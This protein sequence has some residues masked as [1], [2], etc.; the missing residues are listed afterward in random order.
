MVAIAFWNQALHMFWLL[1][2]LLLLCWHTHMYINTLFCLLERGNRE[3]NSELLTFNQM[4]WQ[5]GPVVIGIP[6]QTAGH[7]ISISS[8][9]V[10]NAQFPQFRK[11][12]K[13]ESVMWDGWMKAAMVGGGGRV[14]R[15][16][17]TSLQDDDDVCVCVLDWLWYLGCSFSEAILPQRGRARG[18]TLAGFHRHSSN[19]TL[20]AMS[21]LG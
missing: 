18:W 1:M 9:A 4:R 11:I 8:G 13:F 17:V 19:Y 3:K 10:D 5:I 14:G 20:L 21:M 7:E 2:F 12:H 15:Q 16:D 6:E